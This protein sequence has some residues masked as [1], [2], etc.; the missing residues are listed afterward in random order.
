MN[1]SIIHKRSFLVPLCTLPSIPPHCPSQANID[2]FST[3]RGCFA[4]SRILDKWNHFFLCVYLLL[5]IIILKLFQVLCFKSSFLFITEYYSIVWISYHNC[6]SIHLMETQLCFHF[7]TITNKSA[8]NVH[9]KVL[10]WT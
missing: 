8:M 9:I 10:I 3:V 2:L 5:N 7:F 4:F 1:I 6:L